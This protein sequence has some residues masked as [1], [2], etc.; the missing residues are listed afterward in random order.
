MRVV[1]E[2]LWPVFTLIVLGALFSHAGFPGGAFWPLAARFTY[3]ALFP[4]LLCRELATA[5]LEGL[6]LLPMGAALIGGVL[7][8]TLLLLVARPWTG[9]EGRAFGSVFQGSVRPNTYVGLAVAPPA[10]GVAGA[11]LAA[12]AIAALVPL[13]NLLSVAVLSRYHTGGAPRWRETGWSIVTNPLLLACVLGLA[14]NR[15]GLG[16][17]AGTGRTVEIF[18]RAA[19]PLGLLTVGAG[20]DLRALHASTY[21]IVLASALKLL[22]LPA[23]TAAIGAVLGVGDAARTVAILFAALPCAPSAYVLAQQ[24][25]GDKELMARILTAQTLL[26]AFTLPL[27]WALL[28]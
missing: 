17:L 22:A 26:A 1:V 3:F 7:A 12:V 8:L 2:A 21:P 14:L 13:V 9:L 10:A 27:V 5:R 20:L 23:V 18:S 24:L 16:L 25:G 28:D 19:L 4:A 15:S 6:H 11:P